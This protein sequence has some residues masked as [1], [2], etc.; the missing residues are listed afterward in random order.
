M[1][2]WIDFRIGDLPRA[3]TYFPLIGLLIGAAN[4]LGFWTATKVFSDSLAILATMLLNVFITG[5]L[6][7]DGFADV[8]DGLGG[9]TRERALE[10]MRDS[11]IGTYGALALWFS[12][13]LKFFALQQLVVLHV[14]LWPVLITAPL[15]SRCSGIALMAT[16]KNVRANSPTSGPF[17]SGIPARQLVLTL[18]YTTVFTFLFF[19]QKCSPAAT[20][21][22][23]FAIILLATLVIFGCRAFFKKRLGGIT[24]DCIGATIQI[25]ELTV[26][27]SAAA[28]AKTS[29]GHIVGLT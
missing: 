19:F 2:R 22:I 3:A 15:L 23:A 27:L 21:A 24:G 5:A 1:A 14:P 16:C 6:H 17:S 11:R 9:A 4:A 7:E 18:V 8:A 26:W 20:L 25:V 29:P 28:F 12:L 13:A 10:I